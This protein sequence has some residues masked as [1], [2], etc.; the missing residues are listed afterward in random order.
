MKEKIAYFVLL[1]IILAPTGALAV[2]QEPVQNNRAQ[3]VQTQSQTQ[4][5]TQDREMIQ[6]QESNEKETP[7][8]KASVDAL[9]AYKA[10][11]AN[12]RLEKLQEYGQN[13]ITERIKVLQNITAQVE[14]NKRLTETDKAGI[15]ASVTAEITKIQGLK[16]EIAETTDLGTLKDLVKKIHSDYKIYAVIKPKQIAIMATARVQGATNRL[17]N[18]QVKM[19]NLIVKANEKDVDITTMQA[20]IDD[21]KAKISE[22]QVYIDQ[23]KASF[24]AMSVTDAGKAKTQLED[25]KALLNKAQESLKAAALDLKG[26]ITDYKNALQEKNSTATTSETVES[27][28]PETN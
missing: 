8:R 11:A 12:V 21:Y 2:G 13:A 16:A 17:K 25:G 22:A 5:A 10:A 28:A 4:T 27:A 19:E 9:Q 3:Q 18:L 15:K 20:K 1:A 7:E 23:A 24:M 6:T 26:I 14:A